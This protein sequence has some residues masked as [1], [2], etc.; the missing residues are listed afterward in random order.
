MGSRGVKGLQ[1]M[2]PATGS[3]RFLQLFP[4]Q[5]LLQSFSSLLKSVAELLNSPAFSDMRM[6]QILNCKAQ[7]GSG[8]I[9]KTM[10][11]KHKEP[12]MHKRVAATLVILSVLCLLL[13]CSSF[14]SS[15]L[16]SSPSSDLTDRSHFVFLS[17]LSRMNEC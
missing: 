13:S 9:K 1:Y 7:R 12:G 14:S 15:S 11:V 4:T 5:K 2:T 8:Q 3:L 10:L 17:F 16:L 6:I